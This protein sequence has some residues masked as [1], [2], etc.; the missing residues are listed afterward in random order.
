MLLPGITVV[1]SPL[2]SLM[3]DQYE[4][5]LRDRYGLDHLATFINGDVDFYELLNVATFAPPT[6]PRVTA[7]AQR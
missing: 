7:I 2:K 4:Q 6:K 3:Q 5:R 1:V